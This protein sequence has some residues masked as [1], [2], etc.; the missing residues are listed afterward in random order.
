MKSNIIASIRSLGSDHG[1]QKNKL[2]TVSKNSIVLLALL[3]FMLGQAQ[4]K[5]V[6]P[7]EVSAAFEKEFPKMK[8]VWSQ[9]Y[10]ADDKS[11]IR[12]EAK[13]STSSGN[14]VAAFDKLGNLKAIET[15]VQLG[16]LPTNAFHYIRKKFELEA[17]KEA[18]Q[19]VDGSKNKTYEVGIQMTG[20]FYVL[21]FDKDGNFVQQVEKD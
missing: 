5:I 20:K 19:V 21:V 18:S 6:P 17:V 9:E 10:V 3:V 16:Q 2:S 15:S 11:E 4:N 1:H 12:Y 8:P 13:F 14:K 7:A